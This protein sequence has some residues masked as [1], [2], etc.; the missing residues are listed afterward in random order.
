MLRRYSFRADKCDRIGRVLA[1]YLTHSYAHTH[2]S[3]NFLPESLK[4]ADWSLWETVRAL[5]LKCELVAVHS[6][7]DGWDR[8]RYYVD[9]SLPAFYEG[10]SLP[11]EDEYDGGEAM[12]MHKITW[13]N[14]HCADDEH[15]EAQTA[16]LAVR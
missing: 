1:I 2:K 13:L 15:K 14:G 4:G 11:F 3:L 9:S 6:H 16:Y 5:G 12:P 7:T 8:T 10:P